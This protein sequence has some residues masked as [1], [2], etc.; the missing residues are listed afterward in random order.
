M[1]I[2]L[3]TVVSATNDFTAVTYLYSEL[4]LQ[5]SWSHPDVPVL[6]FA[7][8][9]LPGASVQNH[10]G[11]VASGT[12]LQLLF[13]GD[14]WNTAEGNGKLNLYISRI[15]ALLA[16]NYFSELEQYG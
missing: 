6:V 13:W 2:T 16:S 14:F 5:S 7:D 11:I 10:G 1:S 15:Q 4:A 9:K 12:P 8:N 3:R